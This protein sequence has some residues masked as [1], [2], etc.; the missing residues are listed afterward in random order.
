MIDDDDGVPEPPLPPLT[1]W[2]GSSSSSSSS[3]SGRPAR[4]ILAIKEAHPQ[5][6]QI[7]CKPVAFFDARGCEAS[8]SGCDHVPQFVAFAVPLAHEAYEKHLESIFQLPSF[9]LRCC[10]KLPE[11]QNFLKFLRE[12]KKAAKVKAYGLPVENW[13]QVENPSLFQAFIPP[14]D[15]RPDQTIR[16]H[17]RPPVGLAS[18]GGAGGGMKRKRQF[19][20]SLFKCIVFL[21]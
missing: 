13:G 16:F 11:L 1:A 21:S 7:V 18:P 8:K 4:V 9:K 10:D 14:Q 12:R 2:D 5:T 17:F 15:L 6:K 19:L 20:S 3:I